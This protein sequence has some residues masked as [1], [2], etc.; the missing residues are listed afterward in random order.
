MIAYRTRHESPVHP[1]VCGEQHLS[2][3]STLITRGSSPRVRGTGIECFALYADP[4]FIPACAGNSGNTLG[5]DNV[6]A[7]HPRVCGEQ[8]G[9][10]WR[11][12]SGIGS[13]PRVRGTDKIETRGPPARRFIP[14]CAGNRVKRS[15]S[16]LMRTVH[17]RVCGEQ[18]VGDIRRHSVTGSSPRERGTATSRAANFCGVRFIP[19]CA[20]NRAGQ[21]VRAGL[22][23]VHP[24]V[25]GEQDSQIQ[26]ICAVVGSS[27]RVRGTDW[28]FCNTRWLCRFIPACA[29]NSPPKALEISI[30]T[31]HPRVCGEQQ[32]V[33][34]QLNVGIGSSPRVRGTGCRPTSM[35]PPVRFI[36]A[37]AGNRVHPF[38]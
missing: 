23:P 28:N 37:C 16:R 22:L 6:R 38:Q 36:P 5:F 17:P 30:A 34:V 11:S 31:V 12:L 19:A 26:S 1:R 4:R 9:T 32:Q 35:R 18:A 20:G 13:S 15:Y 21:A 10:V 29:G 8:S 27:P 2:F 33:A 14:A 24:R 25:C 3:N 7:V